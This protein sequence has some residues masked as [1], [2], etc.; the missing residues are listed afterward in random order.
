VSGNDKHDADW[1]ALKADQDTVLLATRLIAL[2]GDEAKAKHLFSTWLQLYIE[3]GDFQ[4][5]LPPEPR[6]RAAQRA[7]AT[8]GI[9]LAEAR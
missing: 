8:L 6:R 9:T 3:A 7:A 5:D 2:H 1:S 4:P